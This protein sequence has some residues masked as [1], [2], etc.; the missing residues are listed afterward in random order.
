MSTRVDATAYLAPYPERRVRRPV[1]LELTDHNYPV[2]PAP[3]DSW[4]P[5]AFRAFEQVAR[6][7]P[8]RD[9]LILGTGSGLDALGAAEIFD[10]R[11][12]TVTEL[13]AESLAGAR[14]NITAHLD[15]DGTSLAFHAGD[16]LACVPADTRVDLIYENLP[17]I[18]AT[19][20]IDLA[21]GTHA[22]RF[23]DATG[24]DV[25]EPFGAYLLALHYRC[26]R[27]AWDLVRPGGGVLTAIGGRMPDEIP[28]GLHR[29]CGY[30]PTFAAFDVKYQAEPAMVLPGYARAER[31]SG[32]E[33][34]FYAEAAIDIVAKAR[35]RGIDGDDL[36]AEVEGALA[37]LA[38]T[39]TEAEARFRDG[40]RPAHSVL[41]IFGRRPG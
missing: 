32:V 30:E 2:E 15:S 13:F 10:L 21:R 14:A 8:V 41:M 24:V 35:K 28:L 12:L 29:E 19:P 27:Q 26:L 38:M 16:L 20:E 17:N 6:Q 9:V 5:I 34:R 39:A 22:G 18:P 4:L 33:F 36:A 1:V 23:F 37:P 25:P 3:Q 40:H 31:E 11:S 7:I